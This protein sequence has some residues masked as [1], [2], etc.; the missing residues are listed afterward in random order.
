MFRRGEGIARNTLFFNGVNYR[1]EVWVNGKPAGAHVGGYSPFELDVTGLLLDG[2][3]AFL[4]SLM[5]T[6]NDTSGSASSGCHIFS[7]SSDSQP[8]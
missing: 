4:I 8:S 2:Y 1:S 3:I 6:A 5:Y 7:N